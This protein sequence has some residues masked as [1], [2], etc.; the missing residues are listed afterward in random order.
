MSY[1]TVE[2]AL[3][4]Q[5]NSIVGFG[6]VG[7]TANITRG[8]YRVL[9]LGASS[10]MIIEYSGFEQRR[11]ELGGDHE[12]DWRFNVVLLNRW[13]DELTAAG[14]LGIMRQAVIDQINT[15]PLLGTTNIYDALVISGDPAP[16]DIDMGGVRY[17]F[18]ILRC[19]ATEMISVS[20]A[21]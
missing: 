15:Q 14:G 8:D 21:E 10:A 18:E 2:T 5:L 12:I 13:D 19:Q 16:E 20:Y 1:T 6:T 11:A 4:A 9:G 3:L 17:Q 7:G